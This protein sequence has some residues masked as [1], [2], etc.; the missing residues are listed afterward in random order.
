MVRHIIFDKRFGIKPKKFKQ[1]VPQK[2]DDT[3]H[4]SDSGVK[5]KFPLLYLYVAGSSVLKTGY[6]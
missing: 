6:A 2:M 5:C 1:N 4:I 3:S